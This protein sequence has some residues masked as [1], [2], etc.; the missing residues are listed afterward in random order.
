MTDNVA[1][2]KK[3]VNVLTFYRSTYGDLSD[4]S[5]RSCSQFAWGFPIDMFEASC[6]I[7][8]RQFC[9]YKAICPWIT[10]QTISVSCE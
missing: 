2:K 5:E 7:K 6:I 3:T 9:L 1:N 10:T 8:V 4:A